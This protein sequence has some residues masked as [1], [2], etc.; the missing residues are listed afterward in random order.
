MSKILHIGVH[1]SA[2]SNSGDTLLFPLVRTIFNRHINNLDW[3][4]Q[5]AWELFDLERAKLV[6][7]EYSALVIGGG[8]LFLRDQQGSDTSNSGWQWNST[9]NAIKAISLPVIVYAVGYNR[10]RDQEDFDPIF[11][12]HINLLFN[13]CSF[14]GLRNYGSISKIKNYISREN[15]QK[16]IRQFCPTT[17]LAQ[18]YPE[19]LLAPP[20]DNKI[21]AVNL[22]FDRQQ[23]R[24]GFKKQAVFNSLLRALLRLEEKGWIIE[25]VSHKIMDQEFFEFAKTKTTNFSHVNLTYSTP[26]EIIDYYS[27]VTCSLGMRGHSQMIPFGLKKPIISLISHD[28]MKFFLEDLNIQRYGIEILSDSFEYDLVEQASY[29]YDNLELVN[30]YFST[31]QDSAWNEST[32]NM[33]KIKSILSSFN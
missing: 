6:N 20:I 16:L 24:F 7:S 13:K 5:Q 33:S 12:E 8:G 32:L 15:Q 10:F 4:L 11:S 23:L 3:D 25:I 9:I 14:I 21:L 26:F 30:N 31:I 28:K 22:A 27:S 19:K 29:I 18:L 2:N 1:N 17:C